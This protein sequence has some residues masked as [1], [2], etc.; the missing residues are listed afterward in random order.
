LRE[1]DRSV[2]KEVPEIHTQGR[3]F[4]EALAMVFSAIDK[5]GDVYRGKVMF[6]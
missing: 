3:T 4:S 1:L 5:L 6:A 2:R